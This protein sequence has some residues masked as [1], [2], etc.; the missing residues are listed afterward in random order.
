MKKPNQKPTRLW[1][2]L[3]GDAG[4]TTV[5]RATHC[6]PMHQDSPVGSSYGLSTGANPV[7]AIDRGVFG[8]SDRLRS[9]DLLITNQMLYQLSYRGN[10]GRI[11]RVLPTG[12]SSMM[13]K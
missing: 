12:T 13:N 11:R 5:A 1:V 7:D 9:D 2:W 6:F 10:L 8:A 4:Y 3:S